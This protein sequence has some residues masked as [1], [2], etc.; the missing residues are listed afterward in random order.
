MRIGFVTSDEAIGRDSEMPHLM[1]AVVAAGLQAEVVSWE[2]GGAHESLDV[3]VIRSTWNY[4]AK[5]EEFLA[6]ARLFRDNDGTGNGPRL[7]NSEA[8]VRWNCHKRYLRELARSG[9]PVVESRLVRSLSELLAYAQRYERLVAKPAV[10]AGALGCSRFGSADLL[11]AE[12]AFN[13]AAAVW[14]E[15]VV[16]PYLD[17]VEEVGE[18]SLV[19]VDGDVVQGL[20]KSP[21]AGNWLVQ[22]EFGGAVSDADVTSEHRAIVDTCT[23]HV[24]DRCG[25]R[26]LYM[27]VDLIAGPNGESLVSE[28]ELIEPVLYADVY[29]EVATRLVATLASGSQPT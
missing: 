28:V 5:L 22:R 2:K 26:P 24:T 15:V 29:P 17:S 1:A 13:E 9:I 11:L 23:A 21:A 27:R 10:G 12:T 14:P 8:T 19:V 3:L 16:Q 20:R 4:F 18:I 6:W 25:A 7:L